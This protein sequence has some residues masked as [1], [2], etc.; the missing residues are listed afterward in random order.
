MDRVLAVFQVPRGSEEGNWAGLRV[1]QE[2]HAVHHQ[3]RHV[4]TRRVLRAWLRNRRRRR[5][6]AV[7]ILELEV[8]PVDLENELEGALAAADLCLAIVDV[9]E[10]PVFELHRP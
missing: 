3:G 7:E 1:E 2:G 8:L 4:A 5:R 6:P 10:A 9:Q